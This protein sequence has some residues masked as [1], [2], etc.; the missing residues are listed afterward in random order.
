MVQSSVTLI[1]IVNFPSKSSGS[2]G[3]GKVPISQTTEPFAPS[4][5][6]KYKSSGL[7]AGV[8]Y[9]SRELLTYSD[10]K[11]IG[12]TSSALSMGSVP[13]LRTSIESSISSPG[14]AINGSPGLYGTPSILM[15]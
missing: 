6:S 15:T 4:D 12:K 11:G 8:K 1:V 7:G 5:G 13:L 2:A 14:S 3:K 10:A 9:T